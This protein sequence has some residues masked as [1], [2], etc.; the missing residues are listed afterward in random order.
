[1]SSAA[2][3]SAVLLLAALSACATYAPRPLDPDKT[4]RAYAARSLDDPGLTRYLD[5]HLGK[6]PHT[7]GFPAL[8]LATAYFQPDVALARAQW[9]TAEAR[10]EAA[11]ARPNPRLKTAT[12]YT[13]NPGGKPPWTL[14]FNIDFLLETA[15][16][17]QDRVAQAEQQALAARARLAQRAFHARSVLRRRLLALYRA[18]HAVTILRA[19]RDAQARYLAF[20]TRATRAGNLSS[21]ARTQTA[22]AL[23]A[24]R[25]QLARAEQ[26]A[27]VARAQTARAIG[28]PAR[29]L[30]GVAL[31]LSLF[32]HPALPAARL[33]PHLE[34]LA[35]RG[36]PD[37]A[38]ALADYAAAEA[39]LKLE[40]ARQYPDLTLGPGYVFDQGAS[41]WGLPLGF[42]LP[43]FNRNQGPIA[44]A[45]SQRD[46]AA[47]RF[48]A[49]QDGVRA[50]IDVAQA[51][52]GTAL[53]RL[54]V[55]DRAMS[56]STARLR[57][58]RQRLGAG[59]VSR[60][61][62]LN[63]EIAR[64]QATLARLDALVDAQRALGRLE[65]AAGAP[66]DPLE[67]ATPKETQ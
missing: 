12:Q 25:L 52:Y 45:K 18:R 54:A 48:L 15:G 6:A 19:Q 34:R 29:A 43:L 59:P 4:A 10:V 61:S 60:G 42:M 16:K 67:V 5:A 47:A 63:A 66:L 22:L 49:L 21:F 50:D 24:T 41:R 27:A 11:G 40:V 36:R 30:H 32:D 31:S 35:L 65:D 8:A 53:E 14:G 39:A 28:V 7:W 46:E 56:Q 17:R 20:L 38:A 1:M 26:E 57:E 9:R 64:S 23:D 44:V 51:D 37:V 13:T 3:V 2:R 55:A 62:L 58:L 33:A